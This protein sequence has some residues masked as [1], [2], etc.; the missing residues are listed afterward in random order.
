[1]RHTLQFFDSE[2]LRWKKLAVINSA[3]YGTADQQEGP[4]AYTHRQADI[5]AAMHDVCIQKWSGISD[6]LILAGEFKDSETGL[7]EFQSAKR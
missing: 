1:M 2:L 4:I 6:K 7:V 5:R 3:N